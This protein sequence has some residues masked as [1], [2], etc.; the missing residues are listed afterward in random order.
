MKID[1][2]TRLADV[3]REI[4]DGYAYEVATPSHPNSWTAARHDLQWYI[5]AN[6]LIRISRKHYLTYNPFE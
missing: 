1:K 4:Q 2:I 6:W 5:D 3:I